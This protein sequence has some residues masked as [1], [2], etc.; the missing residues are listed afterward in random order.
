MKGKT[1]YERTDPVH[2]SSRRGD[3]IRQQLEW[4]LFVTLSLLTAAA[5]LTLVVLASVEAAK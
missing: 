3:R 4:I 5:D 2:L 1:P